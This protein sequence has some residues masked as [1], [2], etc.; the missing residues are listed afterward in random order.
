MKM[1]NKLASL[2]VVVSLFTI[3]SC[4][5]NES[6][7][8][9]IPTTYTFERN[10]ATTID[11]SG[12][13]SRLLMLDQMGDYIKNAATNATAVDATVLSN[14]YSNTN[15]PFD[16]SDLNT[17]GKDLKSKTA[18]SVDYFSL[19]FGGGTTTEKLAVQSFFES[20]F[21]AAASAVAGVTASRGVAGTYLDGS[22]TR[23]FDTNGVEPQQIVLKGLM[24]ACI[25]DQIVNNYLSIH[26][27]DESTNQVDNTNKVLVS[28]TNYTAMEHYWDEAYGYIY[29][30]D[31]AATSTYKYWSSY[32]NQV[33]ADA[34]FNTVTQDILQAF[35]KGRAAIVANDYATRNT[36]INI[37]KQKMA[38]VTA[39]RAVYYLQEAKGKLTT[40]NGA[41]AFHALS[42]G[43]GFIMSLRYT[44]KPN[45]NAPYMSKTE[46]DTILETL[47][48]GTDGF[49]D[50]DHLNENLDSL[51][52]EIAEKFGFTVAAAAVVTVL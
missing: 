13:T 23:L 48:S 43:Y 40:N 16:S 39:V 47:T 28:G 1:Q 2:L 15:N 46:V 20:Q 21:T 35:I 25:L 52:T 5:D 6:S 41:G 44:N 7:K 42:E 45:T 4:T 32:I 17:S 31:V 50:V 19:Y 49:W 24:G 12:Q 22:S 11:F 10:A 51:S 36:Q 29:G 26:K 33:N 3:L 14:M 37:I 8:Y 34:D 38:L 9:D 27:L 18:A 30:G